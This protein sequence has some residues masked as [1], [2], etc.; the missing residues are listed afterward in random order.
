M[1]PRSAY[2]VT[3]VWNSSY[4]RVPKTLLVDWWLCVAC[5]CPTNNT[6]YPSNKR[7][8]VGPPVAVNIDFFG[9]LQFLCINYVWII[10]AQYATENLSGQQLVLVSWASVDIQPTVDSS[11]SDKQK[12]AVSWT[13]LVR[14]D[15]CTLALSWHLNQGCWRGLGGGG[16]PFWIDKETSIFNSPAG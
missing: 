1:L 9:Y 16:I 3:T 10:F 12:H 4:L 11:A 15:K 8:S 13:L 2:D 6:E 5:Y 7:L 14:W